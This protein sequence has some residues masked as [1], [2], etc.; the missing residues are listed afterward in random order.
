MNDA[1]KKAYDL[2]TDAAKQLLTLASAMLTL[3]AAFVRDVHP[4]PT[5]LG[6]IIAAYII[7]CIWPS[8]TLP[9]RCFNWTG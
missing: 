6:L 5:S 9:D 1:Q 3:G 8:R 7:G 4:G 2:T